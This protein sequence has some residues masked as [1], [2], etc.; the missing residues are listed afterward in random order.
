MRKAKARCEKVCQFMVPVVRPFTGST[1]TQPTSPPTNAMISDSTK[2]ESTI[3]PPPKPI[4]RRTAISR[5]RSDT[6]EYMVLRAPKTAPRPMT[7][8]IRVPSTVI[9]V[10]DHLGLLRVVRRARAAPAR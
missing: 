5:E 4:A 9:S 10:R 6:A 3:A 2:N 8:A 7:T 1:A